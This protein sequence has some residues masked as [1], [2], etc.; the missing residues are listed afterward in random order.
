[1][2]KESS[3]FFFFTPTL[4]YGGHKFKHTLLH[5][6]LYCKWV[7]PEEKWGWEGSSHVHPCKEVSF[8]LDSAR[9]K[10]SSLKRMAWCQVSGFWPCSPTIVNWNSLLR[11]VRNEIP[12]RVSTQRLCPYKWSHYLLQNDLVNSDT[13]FTPIENLKHWF[14]IFR[15][16]HNICEIVTYLKHKFG[17]KSLLNLVSF[18]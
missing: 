18:L 5:W 7:G 10:G 13:D 14:Y 2:R 12:V 6:E 1:M 16:D 9:V 11:T 15:N 8:G 4:K 17:P 3:S